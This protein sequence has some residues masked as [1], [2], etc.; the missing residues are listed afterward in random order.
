MQITEIS[1]LINM[2]NAYLGKYKCTIKKERK[3]TN[4]K[5]Q[6]KT[7]QKQN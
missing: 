4:R 7:K 6:N 3:Q 5:K 1:S 2:H